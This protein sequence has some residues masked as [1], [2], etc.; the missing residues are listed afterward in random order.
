MGRLAVD[1]SLRQRHALTRART[2]SI[3]STPLAPNAHTVVVALQLLLIVVVVGGWCVC[4]MQNAIYEAYLYLLVKRP[5][6]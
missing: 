5:C 1:P 2:L 4:P 6:N 3:A